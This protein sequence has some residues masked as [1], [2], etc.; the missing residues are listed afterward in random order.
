MTESTISDINS[1]SEQNPLGIEQREQL[2]LAIHRAKKIAAAEKI[3]AF[4]GWTL[5]VFAFFSSVFFLIYLLIGFSEVALIVSLG[6]AFTSYNEFRGR[7]QL[8]QFNPAGSKLLGANQLLLMVIVLGYCANCVYVAW[9][10]PDVYAEVV[11]QM[12]ELESIFFLISFNDAMI[13]S[14]ISLISRKNL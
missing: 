5:A 14:M 3:A 8:K 10:A 4:N 9:T 2:R 13:D 11:Q 6:L 1:Y 7:K 12:P